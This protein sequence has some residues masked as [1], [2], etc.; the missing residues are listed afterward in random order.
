MHEECRVKRHDERAFE[1][2]P[3]EVVIPRVDTQGIRPDVIV[4][5]PPRK[6]CDP[7]LLETILELQPRARGVRVVQSRRHWRATCACWRMAGTASWR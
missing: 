3:A 1:A 5:D 7:A 4:V 2:G 6:G